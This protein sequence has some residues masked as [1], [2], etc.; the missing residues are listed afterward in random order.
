MLDLKF[1]RENG[2]I[3]EKNNR[4]HNVKVDLKE[5][6]SLD[7]KRRGVQKELEDLRNERNKVSKTKPTAVEIA[8]MRKLGEK[9]KELEEKFHILE[10]NIE[11][12]LW[13]IP[14]LSHSSVPVGSDETGNVVLRQVGDRPKFD[15]K[16]KEHF[17]ILKI[18]PLI[19]LEK[20]A[21]VSGSRFYYLKGK[22]ALLEKALMQYAIDFIIKKDF[23]F[24]LPP[25]LVKEKAMFGTG[26]FPTEKNEI[27]SINLGEDDLYLIGTSEVPLIYYHAD[28]VLN[29]LDLPKK[30]AAFSSC[31][32]REAGSYG[33][34]TKGLIRVHQFNKV[35]MVV[36]ARP[37]ESWAK[38]DELLAIEEEMLQSLSLPYQ[39]VNICSGD[40]G[41]P[42]A[43]KYDCEGWFPGQNRFR[44]LTSTSNTTDYQARRS[45]IKYKTKLGDKE[46][47]HTLNATLVSDRTL[48]AI[49]ENNQRKDGSVKV[50]EVLKPYAGFDSI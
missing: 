36:F 24:I 45:N 9:I 29:E 49:I 44:E 42:A 23:E 10:T 46:Y 50:P 31:F 25:L 17:E 12:I 35:E 15:F 20:G 26:F 34:D 40:L 1:I 41:F 3:V 32:R 7:E 13:Q 21:Q 33:K 22:I 8:E 14:N 11:K 39:V 30:Y 19:D 38:H 43:K 2:K 16:P 37:E 4:N 18:A 5:L 47:L 27:Y 28:E 6:L 48:L